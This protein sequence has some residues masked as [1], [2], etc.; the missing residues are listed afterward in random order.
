MHNF[1]RKTNIVFLQIVTIVFAFFVVFYYISLNIFSQIILI[2]KTLIHELELI[3]GCTNH[4]SFSHHPFLFSGLFFLGFILILFVASVIVKL[5][6]FKISNDRFIRINL[7]NKKNKISKKLHKAIECAKLEN[8][9]IEINIEKP[10]V[11]CF[12]FLRPKICISSKLVK[13]LSLK[14]LVAVLLH[15]KAH[16]DNQDAFKLLFAKIAERVLFFIPFFKFL[17]KQYSMFSELA[18]DELATDKFNNKTLAKALY[19]SMKMEENLFEKNNIAFVSFL[20]IMNERICRLENTNYKPLQPSHFVYFVLSIVMMS[21]I[22][23]PFAFTGNSL[24]M[25]QGH[26]NDPCPEMQHNI[27]NK[28]DIVED[29]RMCEI[30]EHFQVDYFNDCYN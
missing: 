12:S 11:F 3:C 2:S 17:T 4:L 1:K 6:K 25:L 27:T 28:C 15:E 21:F 30:T 8:I 18:A 23:L 19:K 7:N 22:F 16:I 26:A 5:I 10:V 14:E 20:N 29:N 24:S 9:I 13:K